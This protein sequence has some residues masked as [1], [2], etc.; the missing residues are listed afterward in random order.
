MASGTAQA[1]SAF[2]QL[3]SGCLKAFEDTIKIN[4][5]CSLWIPTAPSELNWPVQAVFIRDVYNGSKAS[6]TAAQFLV[7]VPSGES[8]QR[9]CWERNGCLFKRGPY[10]ALSTDYG[11]SLQTISQDIL[12]TYIFSHVDSIYL[13]IYPAWPLVDGAQL[14]DMW[15]FAAGH[16]G[17]WLQSHC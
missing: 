3:H 11:S 8:T 10:L 9:R 13:F 6:G 17:I 14:V 2:W 5:V 12:S 1:A 15:L 7:S 4:G 16:A